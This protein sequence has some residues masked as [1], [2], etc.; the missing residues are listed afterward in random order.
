MGFVEQS[1]ILPATST[2]HEAV[3]FASKLKLPEDITREARERRVNEV[4]DRL[5]L[6]HVAHS[7]VGNDEVR[8]LSGGERR[9]LSIAL[10]L[11][12]RP[13]ILFLDEPTSS[14]DPPMFCF[15]HRN[16][17][18]KKKKSCHH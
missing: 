7:R 17:S 9:R 15:L 8:G 18:P 16:F 12:S 6:S 11:I 5:G 10:E 4:I 14:V 1:D 3:T 13:S 2:V